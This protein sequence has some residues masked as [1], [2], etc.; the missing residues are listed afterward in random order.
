MLTHPTL[1]SVR[2]LMATVTPSNTASQALFR[3]TAKALQ[4]PCE[5]SEGFPAAWFPDG[6]HEPE[7]LFQIG[8]LHLR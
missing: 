4:A 6:N 3:Q 2:Y 8:P 5:V 7:E 1:R